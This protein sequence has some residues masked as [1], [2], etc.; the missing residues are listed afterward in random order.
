MI[1][2]DMAERVKASE[3]IQMS[4]RARALTAQ[5]VEVINLSLGEPD[6]DTPEEIKNAAK[7]ALD[8]GRTKYTPVGGIPEL[9]EAIV[10]K[11]K[12]ENGV[13]YETS[14][15]VVSCGAKHSIANVMMALLN[16]GDEV[17]IPA[18]FWVTYEGITNMLGAKQKY[19]PTSIDSRF[20][21]TPELLD[22]ALSD[23]VKLMIFSSPCNPSG[24]V[25]TQ[26]ELDALAEVLA[27]YPDVMVISDEIYEYIIFEGKAASIAKSPGMQDR[28]I[29]INGASKGYAMTGWRLGYIAAPQPIAT[30]CELIQGQ[31]TSGINSITQWAM[32]TALSMDKSPIY[33]MREQFKER[34]NYIVDQ[35]SN[36]KGVKVL[37]PEGAFYIFPDMSY[38]FGKSHQDGKI[39]NADD[40]AMY[41]LETGHVATVS[42][43][44]FGSPECIRISYAADMD[45]IQTACT[46]IKQALEK[47]Q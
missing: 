47:L 36:I 16:V 31:M 17:L 45:S 6:F 32:V 15:I 22:S 14:Q 29:I 10:Q 8:E 19:I 9:R 46:Q 18:P 1:F 7:K 2:S 20:K 3:T 39:E 12:K 23:K 21:L 42:G 35:F 13:S 28:T 38:Y 40:L 24:E 25:Y 4:Q 34:R 43:K 44:P 37:L 30:K 5:G 27:K 11:L 26:S 33:E 41:L